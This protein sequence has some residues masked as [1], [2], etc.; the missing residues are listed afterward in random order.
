MKRA[1]AWRQY[2]QTGVT[3]VELVVSIVVISVGLA[4]ILIV[5]DRTTASSADP[6]VQ[7]QAVA[8]AEAYLDEILSR[9]FVDPDGTNVGETRATFDNVADYNGLSDNGAR[10]QNDVAIAALAQYNINVAVTPQAL[11]DITAASGNALLVAVT[12]TGP[13]NVTIRLNGYRTNY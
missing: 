10:D 9:D 13:G 5:M 8:I 3:L 12:V 11:S 2:R 1:Y 4:G 7:H 6:M